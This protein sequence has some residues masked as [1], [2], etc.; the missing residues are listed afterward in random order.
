L[1]FGIVDIA[2][3]S[4]TDGTIDATNRYAWSE[5]AGWIDFGSSAGNVHVTDA[6]LTGSAYGENTGWITLDPPTYGG[7][8]NDGDGT[9]SGYAWSEN[10]GWID[11]SNATIGSDGVFA[12]DAYGENIGWISFGTGD[13]KVSTD[14]RP[15]SSRTTST[16]V[17]APSGGS[18]GIVGSGPNAVSAEGIPGYK[19]PRPQIIYPDGRIAYLDIAPPA[20]PALA[21][22]DK[23]ALIAALTVQV[24]AL[25]AQ[26]QALT[27]GASFTRN[28]ALGSTGADAKSLQVWLNAHG[29]PIVASGP[30]SLGNE[31]DYFGPAT[32]SALAAFQA[33]NGISPASGYFGPIT[34]NFISSHY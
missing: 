11:F 21:P 28:L 19:P 12:G 9:L 3:A 16:P 34:R 8:T 15:A 10:A 4:T 30:G 13:N 1:C 31:T 20:S 23:Q 2:R 7:V 22:G 26:I 5:N 27:G 14:W 18:G 6:A 17:P 32:R 25:L 29:Y 33:K 24:N